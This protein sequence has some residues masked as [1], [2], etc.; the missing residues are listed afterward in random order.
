MAG[1][2]AV[3]VERMTTAAVGADTIQA[4]VSSSSVEVAVSRSVAASQIRCLAAVMC[5]VVLEQLVELF[6]V[7]VDPS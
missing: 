5:R 7:F 6:R 2:E 4:A 1:S 3:G